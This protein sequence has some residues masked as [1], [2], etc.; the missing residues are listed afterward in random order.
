MAQLVYERAKKCGKVR[1]NAQDESRSEPSLPVRR[2]L[3]RPRKKATRL[4]ALKSVSGY[5]I[6]DFSFEHP[7]PG[8]EADAKITTLLLCAAWEN[9]WIWIELCTLPRRRLAGRSCEA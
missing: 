4:V 2:W 9:L 3:P 5:W 8:S 7:A 1:I 6:L